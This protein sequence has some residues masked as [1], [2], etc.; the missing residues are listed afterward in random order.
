MMPKE[1][2]P[3]TIKK[4]VEIVEQAKKKAPPETKIKVEVDQ[5]GEIH[6]NEYRDS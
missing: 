6:F 3:V 4:M 1:S 2:D 5:K